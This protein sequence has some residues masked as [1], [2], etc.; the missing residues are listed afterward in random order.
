MKNATISKKGK[1]IL[2][3]IYTNFTN[4]FTNIWGKLTGRFPVIN[5]YP[6]L[7]YS[8]IPALIALL[9]LVRYFL[10]F[11]VNELA[12]L[13]SGFVGETSGYA[14]SEQTIIMS[15]AAVFIGFRIVK[16]INKHRKSKT[17]EPELSYENAK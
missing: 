2:L 16:M 12:G 15:L 11:V 4:K 7:K 5:R 14:V 6:V 9:L 3:F 8:L 10:K 17:N 1:D 13:T